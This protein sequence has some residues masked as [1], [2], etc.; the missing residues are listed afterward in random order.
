MKKTQKTTEAQRRQ[1]LA[2]E[3]NETKIAEFIEQ[4]RK[5]KA[6]LE[7]RVSGATEMEVLWLMRS[8]EDLLILLQEF[9]DSRTEN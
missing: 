2:A 8:V 5:T 1:R 3:L 6:A 7:S 9:D 4:M